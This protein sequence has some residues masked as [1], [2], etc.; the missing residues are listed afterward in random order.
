MSAGIFDRLF[1][2]KAKPPIVDE[3]ED[4]SEI[5][6]PRDYDDMEMGSGFESPQY[7]DMPIDLEMNSKIHYD[8]DKL[9]YRLKLHNTTK[10]MLGDIDI[11]VKTVKKSVV[12]LINSKHVVEMLEPNKSIKLKFKLKPKY[13]LGKSGVYGKIEYF[14]FKSKERKIYRLPQAFV[15]FDIDEINPKRVDEDKWRLICSRLKSYDIETDI[16]D[17]SPREVFKIFQDTLLR[18][19][20]Y[21]LPPI[22]NVNLYR[23]IAKF[24]GSDDD[25]N[26]FAVEAQVIGDQKKSKVLFRIWSGDSKYAM[27]LAFKAINIINDSIKIKNF[28][29][30]T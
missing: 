10:D 13:M 30:E 16:M 2:R 25:E 28:I 15:E 5:E 23:A 8:F 21:M 24:Y 14:D 11:N 20:L 9:E 18:L 12:D 7:I 19:G 4:V 3:F 26:Q 29:V 1:K 17:S 22:E 27:A 6:L